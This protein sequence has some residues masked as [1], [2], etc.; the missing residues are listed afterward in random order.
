[1]GV[2][3]GSLPRLTAQTLRRS[4][5]HAPSLRAPLPAA[6][7]AFI[8]R[9]ENATQ[10]NAGLFMVCMCW[11]VFVC[12]CRTLIGLSSHPGLFLFSS[13]LGRSRLRG[14]CWRRPRRPSAGATPASHLPGSAVR[15]SPAQ[16][17]R[18]AAVRGLLS[19]LVGKCNGRQIGFLEGGGD[20]RRG[21]TAPPTDQED[22]AAAKQAVII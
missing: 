16:N 2:C 20:V 10:R 13:P 7:P 8:C 21:E 4:A 5:R 15:T 3:E 9:K 18:A 19:P 1:M 12:V 17:R 11:C 14:G 6:S 22:Q